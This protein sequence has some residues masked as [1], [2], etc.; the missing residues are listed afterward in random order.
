MKKKCEV[1]KPESSGPSG[2]KRKDRDDDDE[3]YG[4]GKGK[5]KRVGSEREKEELEFRREVRESQKG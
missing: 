2:G 3:E 1:S 5:Q 4:K